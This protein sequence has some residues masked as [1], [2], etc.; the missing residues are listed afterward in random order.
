MSESIPDKLGARKFAVEKIEDS[1]DS[2]TLNLGQHRGEFVDCC[3]GLL[4]EL[5]QI[6]DRE[7]AIS[8]RDVHPFDEDLGVGEELRA[9]PVI[10]WIWVL[11][12]HLIAVR[13]KF[14][15]FC[16]ATVEQRQRWPEA[17]YKLRQSRELARKCP[18]DLMLG[19]GQP[20][21][22]YRQSFTAKLIHPWTHSLEMRSKLSERTQKSPPHL[23]ARRAISR[24]TRHEGWDGGSVPGV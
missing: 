8:C 12:S 2:A 18:C 3:A 21:D 7:S 1:V 10:L 11:R 13:T 14:H 23:A 20:F 15:Y 4:K 17:V 16:V 5:Q 6:P 22:K 9:I 19:L 24:F